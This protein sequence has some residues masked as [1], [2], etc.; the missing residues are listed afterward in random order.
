MPDLDS[1]I[2]R[3]SGFSVN[4]GTWKYMYYLEH[5]LKDYGGLIHYQEQTLQTCEI[6]VKCM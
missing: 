5:L 3:L 6:Y 4:K 2:I 1:L